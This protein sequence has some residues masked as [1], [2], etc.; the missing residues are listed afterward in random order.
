[1]KQHTGMRPHDLV[2]LCAILL[3][4]EEDWYMKDLAHQLK[5]SQSEISESLHRSMQVGLIGPEK[6]R[7]QKLNL[8]EFIQHG[9]KYTFPAIPGTLERGIPTAISAE[10]L[11][12]EL[13]S[14]I[15]YVWPLPGGEMNGVSLLPLYSKL[16]KVC[17]E[18]KALYRIVSLVDTLRMN[19]NAREIEVALDLL[20]QELDI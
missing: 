2:I 6:R 4:E 12:N 13:N 10:P 20:K 5:L 16:P 11:A 17:I 1:M 14:S 15:E 8:I 3:Q 7:V 9:L 18:W 19:Q